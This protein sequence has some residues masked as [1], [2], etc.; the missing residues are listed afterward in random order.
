M[1][2]LPSL[3]IFSLMFRIASHIHCHLVN[4]DNFRVKITVI[5]K[6]SILSHSVKFLL[7]KSIFKVMLKITNAIFLIPG[8]NMLPFS[9]YIL[10]ETREVRQ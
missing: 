10:Y 4:A 6:L 1:I 9:K 3:G 7:T 5:K 8:I 2:T